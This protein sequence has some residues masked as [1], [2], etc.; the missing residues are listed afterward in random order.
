MGVLQIK[1]SEDVEAIGKRMLALAEDSAIVRGA[2]KTPYRVSIGITV[3]REGDDANTIIARADRYMYQAKQG[4]GPGV[5]T[6]AD[7]IG[8]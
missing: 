6:D 4:D 5:M 2:E 3:V 1:A 8:E 7:A